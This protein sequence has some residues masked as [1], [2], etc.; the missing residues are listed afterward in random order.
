MSG[1]DALKFRKYHYSSLKIVIIDNIF[2]TP[3]GNILENFNILRVRYSHWFKEKRYLQVDLQHKKYFWLLAGFYAVSHCNSRVPFAAPVIV[4]TCYQVAIADNG[5]LHRLW[6]ET[7]S[8]LTNPMPEE[9][10]NSW[11]TSAQYFSDHMLINHLAG[12]LSRQV[13]DKMLHFPHFPICLR[14]N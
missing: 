2:H 6:G 4:F 12:L 14:S 3:Y 13:D 7:Q 9:T 1:E 5:L 11:G 10:S 8:S